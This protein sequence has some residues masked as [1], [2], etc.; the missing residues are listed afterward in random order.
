MDHI[1]AGV[2]PANRAL[3]LEPGQYYPRMARRMEDGL[4]VGLCPGA[5]DE[6]NVI[7]IAEG[8]LDVLTNNS[9]AS[10]KLFIRQMTCLIPT[11][12][13]YAIC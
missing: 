9:Q 3:K 12:M 13:K 5:Y 2:G 8:Q 10:A 11:G 1:N 7:A 4:Q 6:R